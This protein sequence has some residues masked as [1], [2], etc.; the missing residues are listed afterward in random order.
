MF[1]WPDHLAVLMF[2]TRDKSIVLNQVLSLKQIKKVMA[3]KWARKV[4]E[5]LENPGRPRVGWFR[6]FLFLVLL[7]QWSF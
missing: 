4:V 6:G 5:S 1:A 7:R 2:A 3:N